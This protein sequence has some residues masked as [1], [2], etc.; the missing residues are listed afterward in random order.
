MKN[1]DQWFLEGF[2][3]QYKLGKNHSK[4]QD[5]SRQKNA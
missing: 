3:R 2:W 4:F 1:E 5:I